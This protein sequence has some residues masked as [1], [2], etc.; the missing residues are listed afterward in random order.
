MRFFH[1]Q[2]AYST[3]T[4]SVKKALYSFHNPLCHVEDWFE[5]LFL[6]NKVFHGISH[7][8]Q[9]R[10]TFPKA[11]GAGGAKHPKNSKFRGIIAFLCDN[12]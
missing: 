4:S 6:K 11:G 8:N 10:R 5:F 12:F 9:G 3:F 7:E 2:G 1:L